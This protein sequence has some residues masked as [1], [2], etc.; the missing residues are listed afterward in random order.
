MCLFQ[1]INVSQYN[2]K[3]MHEAPP[4][5]VE[6]ISEQEK[7]CREIVLGLMQRVKDSGHTFITGWADGGDDSVK[8]DFEVYLDDKHTDQLVRIVLQ[9]FNWK[10]QDFGPYDSQRSYVFGPDGKFIQRSWQESDPVEARGGLYQGNPLVVEAVD[11]VSLELIEELLTIIKEKG[12][13]M[14]D[15]TVNADD[16]RKSLSAEAN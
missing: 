8:N 4:T 5:S 3:A 2:T 14:G 1:I 15:E 6:N 13:Y 9:K 12:R 11:I 10:N 16:K 7:R